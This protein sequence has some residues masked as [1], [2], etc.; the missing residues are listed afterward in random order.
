MK[1]LRVLVIEDE[2]IISIHIKNTL[3]ILGHEAVAVAKSSDI[4]LD[5]VEKIGIDIAL[6][7]INIEGSRDGIDTAK[8]LRDGYN[9][10]IIFLTAYKDVETIKRASQIDFVGYILKPFRND[11][12]EAMLNMAIAKYE[13]DEKLY[14]I[15]DNYS[16]CYEKDCLKLDREVID[17]T[18]NE[19]KLIRLLCTAKGAIVSYDN[20]DNAI[21]YSEPVSDT[22]RRQLFHRIK[23][24]LK[25][26]PLEVVRGVGYKIGVNSAS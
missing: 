10:P 14:K 22:T 3:Q 16:F 7:D 8:I 24:K 11:E 18:E 21:W 15:D 6:V 20:I 2:S 1:K 5:L 23:T 13:L 25:D 9:L 26:F 4:A 12:L 19:T 17:L